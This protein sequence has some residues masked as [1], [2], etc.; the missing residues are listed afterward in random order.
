[1]KNKKAILV[2]WVLA[3]LPFAMI[4]LCWDKL[5]GRVP[6]HWGINGEADNWASPAALWGL[7]V[8]GPV[9]ALLFQFLPRLDP[10]WRNYEKFQGWYDFF[11]AFMPLI[12]V[13]VTAITLSETLSPGRLQVSRV[14][15]FVVAVI[16][17]IVGNMMG[18]VKPN[19]FMG[20][21]TPWALS[22]PD[23]W[24]RT[25]RMG[26]WVFFLSGILLLISVFTAPAPVMFTAFFT[27]LM[28]GIIATYVMS[29]KWFR[30]KNREE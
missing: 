9:L 20:F 2:M 7:V 12:M 22:D 23:V 21:R 24:N 4:A 6:I 3:L 5:P 16:F 10:K 30:D 11:G 28:G 13:V 26:G 19:W 15:S 29:W 14:V 8:T 27:V 25:Q 18:K 17:L 1:M